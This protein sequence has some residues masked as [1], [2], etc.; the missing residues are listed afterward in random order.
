MGMFK[1]LSQSDSTSKNIE[2]DMTPDLAFC[3][4]SAKG[5][6]EG[7]TNTSERTCYFFIDNWGDE[8]KLYLMERGVRHVNILAE[9]KAPPAMLID[10]IVNQGGS[11]SSK[12]NFTVDTALKNWLIA[13]VVEPD[14]SPYL[15]PVI[16][17]GEVAEDFGEPL[18]LITA[19]GLVANPI[20][21][22]AEPC[23]LLDEQIEPLVK[24]YNFFDAQRNPQGVFE[25]FLVDSG[26]SCTVVDLR[27]KL[28]WQSAGLD[29]CSIRSMTGKIVQ[30]NIDG[31]AGYNDWRM[32]TVEEAMSL[33]ET[34][35]NA[36]GSHL[37]PCFSKEQPFIF[38]AA[39]RKPTGYW[40]VDYKRGRLYWS[41][42]TVPGGFCRLCRSLDRA[43]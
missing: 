11:A 26:D 10:C 9:V 43:S 36:K 17:E 28:M 18:P 27:T 42:G 20:A 7:L 32:P 1:K 4:Y 6:R 3:M 2:W 8:P 13:E 14:D 35:P 41:S 21:L 22:P 19:E 25:N 31:F 30:L 24:R 23:T 29:L 38:V 15:F 34:T 33:M 37:H 12:D 40:F 39:R 16:G 5:L